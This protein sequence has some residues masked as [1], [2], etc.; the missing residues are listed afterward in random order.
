VYDPTQEKQE[1]HPG[2]RA[3][4]EKQWKLHP[5]LTIGTQAPDFD[6]PGIDGK[7]HTLAEYK[8]SSV[9]AIL[10]TCNHCPHAQLYEDLIIQM[11][12]DYKAKGVQFVAIQP[13]ACSAIPWDG[14]NYTDVDDSLPSMVI[15][16]KLRGFNF[17]Y[18]Y[19]G[20]TQQIV[21]HYGPKNTPHIFIFDKERKLRYEGRIDDSI[22]A[23]RVKFTDA[24]NAID[25]LLANQPV[26]FPQRPVFGCSIKWKS[27]TER[28]A[29]ETN[30]WKEQPVKLEVADAAFLKQLRTNPTGKYLL[31][32]FWATWC[33]PCVEEFDDL[34]Q[35][36]LWYRTREFE[37][38]TVSTDDPD[39]KAAVQK[40]LDQHHSAV[41]NYQFSTSDVYALQEAFDKNWRSGVPFTMFLAPDGKVL[42]QH[43]GEI[44]ILE[45]R[46]NILS[47]LPELGFTGNNAYWAKS[48]ALAKQ[49]NEDR[50]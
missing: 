2:A 39:A 41:R 35:T 49:I 24:R 19:D 37:L 36:H 23:D 17:P 13:N 28:K 50:K 29:E 44:N 20:D 27:Q 42:Y 38:V 22:R 9:L 45:L 4:W 26:E 7:R 34:L 21:H 11:A 16:A 40:F 6:L 43:S 10:F 47:Y 30:V 12:A 3:E 15:R 8:N 1:K 33:G 18:L 31:I 5:T 32:N 25:Q 46:R 48:I 14:L